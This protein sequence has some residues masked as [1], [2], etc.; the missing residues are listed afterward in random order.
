MGINYPLH[1]CE[2]C[3][4]K[5]LNHVVCNDSFA[6]DQCCFIGVLLGVLWNHTGGRHIW[7]QCKLDPT[8][9]FL[10][11]HPSSNY[12]RSCSL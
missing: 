12:L 11:H 9:S 7:F 2:F 1:L 6:S 4:L 3:P 10:T 8:L 5:K